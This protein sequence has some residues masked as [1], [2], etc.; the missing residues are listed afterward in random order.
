MFD[1]VL[2]LSAS[3][4]AGHMRAAEALERAFVERGAAREVRHVDTLE[5]TTKLFR[6]VYSDGYSYMVRHMPA[7]TSWLYDALNRTRERPR[8]FDR[9]NTQRFV[10]MVVEYRPEIVVCTHF[11]PAEIL[12]WAT[13]SH[14]LNAALSTVLTDFDAHAMWICTNCEH[15]FVASDEARAQLERAGIDG[16]CITVTG[17]PIDTIFVQRKNKR[18]MRLKHGLK[19]DR[20]TIVVPAARLK[21]VRLGRI[22]RSLSRLR[23]PSQVIVLC[24]R[25]DELRHFVEQTIVRVPQAGIVDFRTYSFT[26]E[27]DEL[28]TAADIVVGRPGGLT[29]SEALAVGL[30]FVVV[31]P[32]PGNERRNADYLLEEGAGICCND[33]AVLDY[34]I[35]RLL[36]DTQR[37]ELMKKN[38]M[39]LARPRAALDI[40]DTLL[41]VRER[42][43]SPGG[44]QLNSETAEKELAT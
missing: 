43:D 3:V 26:A 30:V 24:G 10:R 4:G 19:E 12:S 9:L 5:Y 39:R 18:E 14:R 35:E 40:V 29:T 38:A 2:I 7:L 32:I 15:Y 13:G 23:R 27:L 8:L 20:L 31:G 37:F 44:T 28:M 16:A 17:I 11:L 42:R 41:D 1:K 22:V 25:N 21:L 33:P 6:V 36:D 34:K